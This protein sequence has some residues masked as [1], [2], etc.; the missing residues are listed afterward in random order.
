MCVYIVDMPITHYLLMSD[1]IW[2]NIKNVFEAKL[3]Y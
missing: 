2:N 3:I 1:M